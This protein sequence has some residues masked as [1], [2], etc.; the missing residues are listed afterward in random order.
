MILR[1][2]L[3]TSDAIFSGLKIAVPLLFTL[4]LFGFYRSRPVMQNLITGANVL[5]LMGGVMFSLAMIISISNTWLN[6]DEFGKSA[7]I[8]MISGPKWFQFVLPVLVFGLLPHAMWVFKFRHSVQASMGIVMAWFLSYFT[9]VYFSYP[10]KNIFSFPIE[11]LDFSVTDF[12]KKMVLFI[13]L[14]AAVCLFISI[15]RKRKRMKRKSL[16]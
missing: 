4:H 2:L 11:R 13:C 1:T 12:Y 7:M 3:F 8:D 9:I 5:L 14:L 15:Q 16:I 6:G 10:P